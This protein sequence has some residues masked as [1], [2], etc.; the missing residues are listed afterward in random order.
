MLLLVILCTIPSPAQMQLNDNA[1]ISLLTASPWYAVV[2]GFFGHTAIRVLDDSTGVD[3]V[4]N[5]GYFDTS[6]PHFLYNFVR[7]KTDYI[8]GGIPFDSFI[9]E[10]GYK[11]QQVTEQ[12]L[13]LS[14]AEKQQLYQAL[15][16]NALPEN[17]GYRYNYFYDNCAT[18]P[19]DMVEK[20]TDGRIEYPATT[21]T[22]SYRDL[23]HECVD[24]Y[25]WF[26][27]GIDLLIGSSAD[28]TINVRTK[29][30]IP[31]YLMDSFEGAI[32]Q[33]GDSLT[34][35]LVKN[36]EI[37]LPF[38]KEKNKREEGVVFTPLLTAF[39]LLFLTILISMIQV[40]KM[41]QTKLTRLYDTILFAIAGLAGIILLVLM[42]FSEHPATNPNWNFVWLNPFALIAAFFFW[43][44]SANKAVYFYHFIN[45]ALLMLFLLLWWLI[46]QQLPWATIPFSMSLC[47]RSGTNIYMLRKRR[48]KNRQFT[49]SRHL[50]AGWGGL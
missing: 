22:Q 50:K 43:M 13:N 12:E 16:I 3:V 39:V 23:V 47:L 24:G 44:K 15:F 35:P 6:Q 14:P 28:S 41:N 38:D 5:Y 37:I 1:K 27:F 46:P 10:Y 40:V 18:R 29:M 30:F 21:P 11:G 31:A 36:S 25:P 19:R 32:I 45:F 4:Y 49:T 34:E 8:L 26:R 20:Y 33:R 42:Y 48:L 2:Y 17:C 7:G 9:N